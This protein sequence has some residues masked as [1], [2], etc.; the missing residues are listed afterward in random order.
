MINQNADL[1]VRHRPLL[2]TIICVWVFAGIAMMIASMLLPA[3][4]LT[5][6]RE[7]GSTTLLV[8]SI[9]I[10]LNLVGMVGYWRMRKYGVCAFA[11]MVAVNTGW[12]FAQ[13]VSGL[14]NL[15]GPIVVTGVGIY[16]WDLLDHA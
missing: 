10:V 3:A 8:A 7:Y 5:I 4:R 14:V 16:Y 1:S 15:V 13:G 11:A 9:S 2:V 6:A 12:C